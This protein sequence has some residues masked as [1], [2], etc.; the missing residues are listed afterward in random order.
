MIKMVNHF[1]SV[2]AQSIEYRVLFLVMWVRKKS[3]NI[4]KVSE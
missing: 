3:I 4:K 2:R 1:K